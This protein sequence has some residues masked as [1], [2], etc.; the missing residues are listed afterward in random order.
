MNVVETVK[1]LL[2]LHFDTI[3]FRPDIRH[4]TAKSNLKTPNLGNVCG[5]SI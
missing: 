4:S 5:V 1:G 2:L 3:I